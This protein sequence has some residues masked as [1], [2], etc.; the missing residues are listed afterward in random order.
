MLPIKKIFNKSIHFRCWHLFAFFCKKQ[1]KLTKNEEHCHNLNRLMKFS[2]ILYVDASQQK[3]LQ[4]KN[5]FSIL[6]FFSR[7]CQ[8]NCYSR[9]VYCKCVMQIVVFFKFHLLF[10]FCIFNH[11]WANTASRKWPKNVLK[12]SQVCFL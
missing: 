2:E 9:F 4:Q 3:Q 11:V 12:I 5:G 8:K 10:F 6:A 1:L 7:I